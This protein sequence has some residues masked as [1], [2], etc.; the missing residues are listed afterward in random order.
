MKTLKE[1]FVDELADIYDAEQRIVRALPK[2][3]KAATCPKLSEA[4]TSHLKETQG[5][6]TRLEKVFRSIGEK[7]RGK[8][9]E[10]AVG[11]LKE[12]DEIASDFKNSPA[13]N[14]AL[15][16]AAQKVEHYEIASYGC[17][18]EWAGLLGEETAARLLQETLDEE[19]G[20]DKTLTKLARSGNN[21]EAQEESEPSLEKNRLAPRGGR[22]TSNQLRKASYANSR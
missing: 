15:I 1:L 5:Q 6:V 20:A 16:S 7:A 12:G 13:I 8:K 3:A 9:C 10:A 4:F 19:K 2:L 18:Q 11:L 14:A 17:L 21:E 22:R